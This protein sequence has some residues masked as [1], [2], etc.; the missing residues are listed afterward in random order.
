MIYPTSI[1]RFV[2][3]VQANTRHTLEGEAGVIAQ[4]VAIPSG[5][6]ADWF[7]ST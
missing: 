2:K 5:Q 4:D 1:A 6:W 7:I 3:K